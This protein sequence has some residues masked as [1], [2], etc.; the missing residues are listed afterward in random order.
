MPDKRKAYAPFSLI[1]ESG[2]TNAPVEGYIDV[3]Q[4]I[5]PI[6]STGTVNENGVWT[7]VKS[8]DSEFFGFTK[9]VAV[10][11]GGTTLSP[12]T[13][14]INSIDMSGFKDLIVAIKATRAGSYT[15]TAIQGPDTNRFYNLEPVDTGAELRMMFGN[16][17]GGFQNMANDSAEVLTADVWEVFMLQNRVGGMKNLQ[18]KVINNAGGEAD[19]EVAFLRL[20]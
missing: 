11:N 6:V 20:V 19:I 4:E 7:G 2:V 9:H 18:F 3:N 10:A 14:N 5:Q 1:T 8:D 13:G 12:D 16:E 17:A 15:L